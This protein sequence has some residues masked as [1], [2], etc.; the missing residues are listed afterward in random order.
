M[1]DYLSLSFNELKGLLPRK[2]RLTSAK[3]EHDQRVGDGPACTS[4]CGDETN[5]ARLP[6]RYPSVLNYF[7]GFG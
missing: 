4:F 1:Y 7:Q 6:Q 3:D 5:L 2:R